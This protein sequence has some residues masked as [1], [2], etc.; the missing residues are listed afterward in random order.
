MSTGVSDLKLIT[1]NPLPTYIGHFIAVYNPPGYDP[2]QVFS[3]TVEI[4][5]CWTNNGV[6]LNAPT[7][8]NYDGLT[9]D[10]DYGGWTFN[11]NPT[12][13]PISYGTQANIGVKSYP[14]GSKFSYVQGNGVTIAAAP[15][16]IGLTLFKVHDAAGKPIP[17]AIMD[18]SDYS[19]IQYSSGWELQQPFPASGH[20]VLGQGLLNHGDYSYPP[21]LASDAYYYQFSAGGYTTAHQYFP[22]GTASAGQ[23]VDITLNPTG[24]ASTV[25]TAAT[26]AA[27]N[28]DAPPTTTGGGSGSIFDM[29]AFFKRLADFFFDPA[30]AKPALDALNT[31]VTKFVTWGPFGLPA[32]CQAQFDYAS[33]LFHQTPSSDPDY[34]VWPTFGQGSFQ[35]DVYSAPSDYDLAHQPAGPVTYTPGMADRLSWSALQQNGSKLDLRPYSA[36]ILFGRYFVLLMCWLKFILVV[37]DQMT[38]EVKV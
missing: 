5:D 33:S 12:S 36:F 17:G 21:G 1:Q 7:Y 19:R 9:F 4:D 28:P 10:P 15:Y 2:S 11:C 29:D 30:T 14:T 23:T 34:W 24:T 37:R 8:S 26:T 6:A 3:V 38:P 18:V 25:S 22:T 20:M 16:L 27:D 13:L 32:Q 31:A 35:G